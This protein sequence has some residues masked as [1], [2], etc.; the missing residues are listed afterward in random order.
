[1]RFEYFPYDVKNPRTY[2]VRSRRANL[3]RAAPWENCAD[4]CNLLEIG[5]SVFARPFETLSPGEQAKIL[6]AALFLRE[7]QFLLIDEPTN[8]LDAHAREI[9]GNYLRAKSGFILVSHDRRFLD[10]CVDHILSINRTDIQI[11]RATFLP[12][13]KKPRRPGTPL[14]TLKTKSQ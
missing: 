8:H 12:N 2:H 7:G 1:M 11:R 14:S 5:D 4:E 13:S 3:P 10:S 9:V 6:L